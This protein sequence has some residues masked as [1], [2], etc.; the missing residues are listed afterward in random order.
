MEHQ[1]RSGNK[2]LGTRADKSLA[3]QTGRLSYISLTFCLVLVQALIPAVAAGQGDSA[4]EYELK[5]AMLYDLTL[6][7]EW[8]ASAYPDSQAP[9]VLCVL[10]RDPFGPSL[11]SLASK[12]T[13]NGRPMQIRHLEKD[14]DLHACHILYI[15]SSERKT[16][17]QTISSL[18]G[19]SVLTVGEMGQ[20][21]ARGGMIQLSLDERQ[22]HFAINL[23]AVSQANLR[24]SSRLLALARIV[25]EGSNNS[26][27]ESNS[28]EFVEANILCA[29]PAVRDVFEHHIASRSISLHASHEASVTMSSKLL[30]PANDAVGL[31]ASGVQ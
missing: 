20:F 12:P 5:A 19:S 6:F 14:K 26:H 8:P 2:S 7:V 15:S 25:R 23:D 24:I 30:S 22:V 28:E 11:P 17:F 3:R 13:V 4:G 1:R 27:R 10:G 31:G 29:P 18:K 21:A 16:V 9:T